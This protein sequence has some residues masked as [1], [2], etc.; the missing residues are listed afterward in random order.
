MS[1]LNNIF[2]LIL[3]YGYPAIALAVFLTSAGIPLPGVAII[4]VSG[5][6]AA[7]GNHNLIFLFFLITICSVAGDLVDYFLGVK[8][9]MTLIERLS[10]QSKFVKRTV[11]GVKHFFEK[12][13]AISIFLTRWLITPL[14][15]TVS[16]LA[17]I[18]KYPFRR[19][20]LFD[21]IGEM[22]SAVIFLG[23]GY[24]FSVDW[25]I[26]WNDLSSVDRIGIGTVVGAALIFFS[27]RK[28]LAR[29]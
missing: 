13:S 3:V 15:P 8:L 19:F 1:I 21:V 12:W 25:P 9:G 10:K 29:R 5:S 16:V 22:L 24:F 17:G 26:L 23:L 4:L 7:S 11:S 27:L 20:L 6:L 18:T 2:T 14:G 28:I